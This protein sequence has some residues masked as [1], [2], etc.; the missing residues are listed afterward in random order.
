MARKKVR[1]AV[2][3]LGEFQKEASMTVIGLPFLYRLI[4]PSDL[5]IEGCIKGYSTRIEDTRNVFNQGQLLQV[6]ACPRPLFK[7]G[8]GK[9]RHSGTRLL[10]WSL[11][12]C[13]PF[14][15][16]IGLYHLLSDHLKRL[17][18]HRMGSL[19]PSLSL[20]LKCSTG[21]PRWDILD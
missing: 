17:V 13:A 4:T 16:R 10:N 15:I 19:L 20:L 8:G 14:C 21:N 11:S 3:V 2:A 6:L 12:N 7:F 9:A 5:C 18:D 1:M